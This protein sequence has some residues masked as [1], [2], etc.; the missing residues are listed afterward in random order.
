MAL[1]V[2]DGT[3][4]A[5]AESYVSVGDADVYWLTS[6]NNDV[7]W[8][9]LTTG[10]KETALRRATQYLDAHFEFQGLQTTAVFNPQ[11]GFYDATQALQWPRT[12]KTAWPLQPIK[13]ACC[14]LAHAYAA[15]GTLYTDVT[16]GDVIEERVG[17][18]VTR[19]TPTG[20]QGS[21]LFKF[22]NEL[23]EA[24]GLVIGG[25]FNGAIVTG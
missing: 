19:Y 9:G 6:M 8:A 16:D 11:T 25:V 3:G 17:P 24:S 23:L 15:N 2:E 5:D 13:V 4:R 21:T 10:A 18:I 1:I 14:E 7:T 20:L 22:V 12:I